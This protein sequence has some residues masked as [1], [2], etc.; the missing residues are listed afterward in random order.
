M[1]LRGRSRRKTVSFILLDVRVQCGCSSVDRVL[2]SEAK[3]RWFD[4]SQPHQFFKFNLYTLRGNRIQEIR[5]LP[6]SC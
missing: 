6:M 5:G 4:P 3:G 1:T 2:A